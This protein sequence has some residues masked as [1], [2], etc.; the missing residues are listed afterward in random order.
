MSKYRLIDFAYEVLKEEKTPLTAQEIWDLGK[1]KG[2]DKKGGFIGK[3][4]WQTIHKTLTLDIKD[5]PRSVFKKYDTR[6]NKFYLN[7]TS[8]KNV[9]LE[10]HNNNFLVKEKHIKKIKERDLHPFLTYYMN[11]YYKVYTKTIFHEKSSNKS[12]SHWLH[13]DIVGIQYSIEDWNRVLLDFSKQLSTPMIKMYSFELK[14]DLG[15]KNL[16][17]SFF[18]AVS[19]SSWANEGYLVASNIDPEPSFLKELERLTE[20]FGIG[21]IKLDVYDPDSTEIVF[22]AKET[23]NLDWNTMNKLAE[24]NPDFRD[25]LSR[26]TRDYSNFEIIKERYD[27]VYDNEE[28]TKKVRDLAIV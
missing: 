22:P 10:N 15:F 8:V 13:P 16:R 27:K 21:L 5:N 23:N 4:A 2:Y 14:V 20:S 19:N 28:L 25:F 1:D 26:V 11:K 24:E 9:T 3:K 7:N 6:P 17:E 12:Y 18:Q